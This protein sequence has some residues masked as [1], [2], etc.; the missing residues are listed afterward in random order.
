MF[1]QMQYQNPE[2]VFEE[3][4][5]NAELLQNCLKHLGNSSMADIL[6]RVVT[7]YGEDILKSPE[8]V[9]ISTEIFECPFKSV[10]LSSPADTL[11][12]QLESL[13]TFA[14]ELVE[15]S[16]EFSEYICFK[17]ISNKWLGEVSA[18]LD[19]RT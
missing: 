14:A 12:E 4:A 19:K 9:K 16:L 8:K 3:F 2:G 13:R 1:S 11:V 7:T 15:K 17:V 10:S 5:T 18:T 6:T